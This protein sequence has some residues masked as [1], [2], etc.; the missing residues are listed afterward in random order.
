MAFGGVYPWAYLSLM[1]TCAVFA[2][3]ALI[4][5]GWRVDTMLTVCAACVAAVVGLQLIPLAP[6]VLRVVS[7][8]SARFL[9]EQDLGYIIAT[10]SGPVSHPVSVRPADTWRFLAFFGA[11][12]ALFAG[13]LSLRRAMSLRFVPVTVVAVGTALALIGI[14]QTGTGSNLMYGVWAPETAAA[15]FGPFVNRNHFATWMLMA[16]PVSLALLAAQLTALADDAG[17]RATFVERL[18][19]PRAGA[20]IVTAFA[21]FLIAVALLMTGSRSGFGGFVVILA[22]GIWLQVRHRKSIRAAAP[23]A[24]LLLGLAAVAVGWIGWRPIV[25]RINEMPGT[26]LSGRL[27][28]WREAGRIAQDFW[29]TGS[30]LNTYASTMIGYHDPQVHDFFWTPHNDYLQ[31]LCDGGILVGIPLFVMFGVLAVRIVRR[32][33]SP[34]DSRSTEKWT[35][36]GAAIGLTAVA[37]QEFFDF[38]LQTPANA[39]LFTVLA[40]YVLAS[41]GNRHHARARRFP[42]TAVT[43][44]SAAVLISIAAPAFAQTPDPTATARIHFGALALTP[45]VSLTNAGIDTNVFND[46]TDGS[47]KSDFTATLQPKVDLWMHVGT[48][49]LSGTVIEDLVYYKTYGSERAVNGSYR[50]GLRVPRNRLALAGNVSYLDTRDRPGFEIDA[51]SQRQELRY[52]G[53]IEFRVSPKTVLSANLSRV[54]VEFSRDAV[55]L[56]TN[57]HDQLNRTAT[58]RALA[59]EYALTPLTTVTFDVGRNHDAFIY[60][61]L[62]DTTST[63]ARIG[64]KFDPLTMLRGSAVIGRRSFRPQLEGVEDYVGPTGNIDL[65]Y[66]VWSSTL[67]GVQAVWDVQ[68]SVDIAQ[69]YYVLTGRSAS[70]SRHVSG[71]IDVVGRVGRQQ[72]AYRDRVGAILAVSNRKDHI[73]TY[74]G[75]LSYRLGTDLRLGLNFDWA[76]RRSGV[77]GHSYNDFKIGTTITYGQ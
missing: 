53:A 19:S 52:D 15:V 77:Q 62:R 28:A 61:P 46:P 5:G 75:G 30:G 63:Q 4:T 72:L 32:S 68:Y 57:L 43:A 26:R 12:F 11:L 55:F 18:G 40:A 73:H 74:G 76:R 66:V 71:P 6:A 23:A 47:P 21:C 50:I 1:A 10:L 13:V 51:R 58:S 3:C 8:A 42:S 36:Y 38:G 29:V 44:A 7:P 35:R 20:A 70:L 69:P 65:S 14:T 59:V 54:D 67:I 48:A 49:L 60:S 25:A 39:V 16:L 24:V 31:A 37:F 17:P 41:D 2:A 56:G 34:L 45:R 9:A 22:A 64:V 27:D 33:V